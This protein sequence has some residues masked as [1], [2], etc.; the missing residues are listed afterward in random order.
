[1]RRWLVVGTALVVVLGAVFALG[2]RI[3]RDEEPDLDVR[4]IEPPS[5]SATIAASMRSLQTDAEITGFRS[6]RLGDGATLRIRGRLRS[7]G[8]AG[9]LSVA[10]RSTAI[11]AR[12]LRM[13]ALIVV[14]GDDVMIQREGRHRLVAPGRAV[15]RGESIVFSRNDGPA[16]TLRS[17][18]TF[19]PAANEDPVGHADAIDI[20]ELEE[21]SW[22]DAPKSITLSDTTR[23]TTSWAGAG[24]VDVA[25]R[26]FEHEFTVITAKSLEGTIR[27]TDAGL[28]LSGRGTAQQVYLDGAPQL[29]TKATCDL[30][31]VK[32]QTSSGG[33]PSLT[34]APR[35]LGEFDMLMTRIRPV[36]PAA[37]WLSLGLAPAPNMFG[38]EVRRAIGGV[39]DGFRNGSAIVSLLVPGHADRRDIGV[40][41][42]DGTPPGVYD[43]TV[44]IE[45]NFPD[46]RVPFQITVE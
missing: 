32:A 37:K 8:P 40:R 34:W 30:I 39:T 45:G 24:Q 42:P 26:S 23:S 1:M 12:E 35:N 41:V 20:R 36:G 10:G 38:D 14:R 5:A 3:G 31:E 19:F 15:V 28:R 18:V 33:S 22:L 13:K 4:G 44:I 16:L 11:E 21:V 27:R 17:P 2:V 46:V 9:L 7:D 43:A 6:L 25:G 29:A